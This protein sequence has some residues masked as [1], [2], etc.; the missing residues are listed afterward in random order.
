MPLEREQCRPEDWRGLQAHDPSVRGRIR[1]GRGQS[2]VERGI[3]G[4]EHPARE[5]D[6]WIEAT[7]GAGAGSGPSP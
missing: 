4:T 5:H 6:V 3:L 2:L 1:N 7:R